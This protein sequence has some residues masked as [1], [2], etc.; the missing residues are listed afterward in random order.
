LFERFLIKRLIFLSPMAKQPENRG[1]LQT[2]PKGFFLI[3]ARHKAAYQ[4]LLGEIQMKTF[5]WR[6]LRNGT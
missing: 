1:L 5:A 3:S 4:S 2:I 6:D